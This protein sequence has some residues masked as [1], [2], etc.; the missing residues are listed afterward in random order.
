LK[1]GDS[2]Q[3][4][5]SGGNVRLTDPTAWKDDLAFYMTEESVADQ[6]AA[7]EPLLLGT[8]ATAASGAWI[9]LIGTLGGGF[10][11]VTISPGIRHPLSFAVYVAISALLLRGLHPLTVR[12]LG[13]SVAWQAMFGFFWTSLLGL[14]VVLAARFETRW[15]AYGLSVGGGAFVG[16]M[17]GAFPPG[18]TRN[19]DAWMLAFPLAPLGAVVATYYLRHAGALE[20]IGAAAGAGA[21][22]GGIL[23][24]PMSVL[25]V[26]LSDQAQ[27]LAELGQ[28]YLHNETFAPKAVAFF[29][30]A[31]AMSPNEA[32]YYNLRAV[33][34]SRMN[35]VE[36]ASA[37]WEKALALAPQDPEPHVQRGVDCLRRGAVGEAV[38]LFESALATNADHARAHGYLGAAWERQED[39]RRAFT[40]Y[41]RAI[42]LAQEDAKGYCDRSSANFRRG[43][44]AKALKDAERAVRL[45]DH[46]G[47]AYAARGEALLMLE[48]RDEALESFQ[49]AIDLG[50]EPAVHEDVLRKM[51]SIGPSPWSDEDEERD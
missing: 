10:G 4:A 14:C 34:L 15:I 37:D 6:A 35:E 50:V 49:E 16:M 20:T 25:L 26:R 30:R 45:H 46:L 9:A 19:Q 1:S 11:G 43:D 27:G 33:G 2:G 5:V 48:R 36:R 7:L 22:A 42:A 40:H 38:R 41:D 17:Y 29:D 8:G 23:I 31:I 47:A 44:Y 18:N 12:L 24:A 32:R 28:L 51:E 21:I 13:S 3:R 39:L